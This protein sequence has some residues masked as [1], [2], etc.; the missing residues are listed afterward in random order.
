ML[1]NAW[2]IGLTLIGLCALVLTLVAVRTAVR[3]LRFW[4]P[5]SDTQ[6]QIALENEVWLASTLVAYGLGFQ[7]L[8]A[9]LFVMA[10]DEF[11]NM[12][13]GAMCATGSLLANPFG[14]PALF[15]K[16]TGG[17]CYGGW[18]IIHHL[19]VQ[20]EE[21]PLVRLKF[22]LLLLLLPLLASDVILQTLYLAGLDP[23]IITSCC[24]T[25]FNVTADR[26]QGLLASLSTPWLVPA[27]Y[28]LALL[29]VAFGAWCLRTGSSRWLALYSASW[30]LYLPVAVVALITF[31]SSYIYAMPYHNCPFCILKPEYQYVGFL[32]YFSL[33]PGGFFG[34]TS[35]LV[36]PLRHRP[37]LGEPVR[38][39]Q[40]RAVKISLAAAVLFVA[41]VSWYPVRYFFFGGEI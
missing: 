39:Y 24:A 41:L 7:I 1:L 21:Y 19:D 14:M 36:T 37:G 12:I 25:V 18:L 32:I 4:D 2:S 29:V 16:L 33:F 9:V 23:D 20:S 28:L 3:V 11:S 26:S 30:L 40:L 8:S 27:H 31:F 15:V 34:V 22:L 38:R 13:T 35:A 17:F 6:L 5:A 10:A